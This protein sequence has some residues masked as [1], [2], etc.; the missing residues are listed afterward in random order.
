MR[1]GFYNDELIAGKSPK[2]IG[3]IVKPVAPR[4]REAR[5]PHIYVIGRGTQLVKIGVS[6]SPKRRLSQLQMG[7]AETLKLHG[8]WRFGA[9]V[10]FEVEGRLKNAFGELRLKGEWFDVSYWTM[11]ETIKQIHAGRAYILPIAVAYAKADREEDPDQSVYAAALDAGFIPNPWDTV[12]VRR[13]F[14]G[15]VIFSH[16]QP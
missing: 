12:G 9:G 5:A 2:A 8:S 15:R 4:D 10:A 14:R 6:K 7:C 11:A 3:Q 13:P 1:L 16:A